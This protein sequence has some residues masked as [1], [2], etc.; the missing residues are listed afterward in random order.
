MHDRS[1]N[2]QILI[3][4][5]GCGAGEE[6]LWNTWFHKFVAPLMTLSLTFAVLPMALPV[7]E[8]SSAVSVIPETHE[9]SRASTA[10]GSGS[11]IGAALTM[12]VSAGAERQRTA[13]RVDF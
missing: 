4:C 1:P 11:G 6:F 5:V 13:R 3:Y 8:A 10:K 2:H 12:E 7:F 9:G